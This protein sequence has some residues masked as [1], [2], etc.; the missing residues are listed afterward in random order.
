MRMRSGIPAL[1]LAGVLQ[2]PGC[3]GSRPVAPWDIGR[4]NQAEALWQGRAFA[5]YT[6]EI[7]TS[8]FCPPEI[9]NW[10]RVTVQG[11]AVVAAEAVDPGTGF[12]VT[13]LAFWQPID[14]LFA[15]L[16]LVVSSRDSWT[17]YQS[18]TAAYD[19]TLGYPV[20]IE[21]RAREGIADGDS[22]HW[23]RNV[24]PL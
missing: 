20:R 21:Y 3:D 13:T 15:R 1:V 17:F 11:G 12:P 5:D 23:L 9:T 14:S 10:V 4:L 24:R 6:Y 19:A 7:R 22:S 8:C 16:R 2:A 18:V